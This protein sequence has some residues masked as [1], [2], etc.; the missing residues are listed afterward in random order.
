MRSVMLLAAIQNTA[1]R[2]KRVD[3]WSQGKE[4]QLIDLGR[5]HPCL[6]ECSPKCYSNRNT[7]VKVLVLYNVFF[8]AIVTHIVY[9]VSTN[10]SI[11]IY[12]I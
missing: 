2:I 7:N 10:R 8:L 9:V 12:I 1:L 6:F 4:T 11:I 5:E 3:T